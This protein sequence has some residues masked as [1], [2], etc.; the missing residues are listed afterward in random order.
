VLSGGDATSVDALQRIRRSERDRA[1]GEVCRCLRGAAGTRV[2][3]GCIERCCDL[4]IGTGGGDREMAGA[5]FEI[6]IKLGE[7][8][9]EPTPSVQWH[10]CIA[11]GGK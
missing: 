11:G 4:F 1:V 3:C 2:G 7:A 6:D 9:V 10:R 8:A 5:F